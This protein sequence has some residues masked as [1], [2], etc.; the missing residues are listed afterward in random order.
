MT[1]GPLLAQEAREVRGAVS[2]V[3]DGG[4]RPVPG[5]WVVL[6]RVGRDAQGALDS[7]RTAADGG[8]R[9]RYTARGD[10]G[11]VYFA[12][13]VYG[14][15]AYF[16]PPLRTAAAVGDA[17]QLT[18]YDTAGV[19]VPITVRGRH[20]IVSALDSA[21]QRTVVEVFELENATERTRV[22]NE[23]AAAWTAR[24]PEGATDIRVGEGDFSPDAI[25]IV[26]GAVQLFAPLSP[27][28][29]QLSFSYLLPE[30]AF[31][32]SWPVPEA[33]DLL[34]VL[35]EDP[36]ATVAGA[37]L[38]P[39]ASVVIDGRGFQRFLAEGVAAGGVVA[40][41]V[42]AAGIPLRTIYVV[43][44]VGIIGLGLLMG[45]ARAV[46]RPGVPTFTRGPVRVDP[47]EAM[48]ARIAALDHRFEKLKAP[49]AE[50]RA[51][52]QAERDQLKAALADI[53]AERDDRL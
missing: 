17:A 18:V 14:G 49:S 11:A 15:V 20:V 48:A 13:T 42:P 10:T 9:F 21:K 19:E 27:G 32:W 26:D 16:T 39:Q 46:Q 51:A 34:E 6:H 25:A 1:A 36:T 3:A 24:L 28:M 5:A 12:S 7:V 38:A 52:W 40:I 35:V 30:Q 41:T 37:G 29:R 50:D 45:L 22:A 53:L 47:A 23:Q 44:I 33:T 8:Y 31:P 4:L 2:R 43:G